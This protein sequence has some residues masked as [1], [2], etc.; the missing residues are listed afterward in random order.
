MFQFPKRLDNTHLIPAITQSESDD[1]YEQQIEISN[2]NADHDVKPID[3]HFT[4]KVARE[5]VTGIEYPAELNGY[6]FIGCGVRTKYM[7][8]HA[9]ATGVYLKV[10]PSVLENIRTE[11]DMC[12]LLI[13][14]SHP[15]VFRIVLNR[16]VTS[17]QYIGAIFD[18]LTPLMKGD[19]MDK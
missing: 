1:T 11:K 7:I 8:V 2:E 4:G 12:K 19:D 3:I 10:E 5:P 9:Y 6:K 15:R 17:A 14:P 18:A 16:D 13:D